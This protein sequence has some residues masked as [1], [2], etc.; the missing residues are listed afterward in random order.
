[1]VYSNSK[2]GIPE[3]AKTLIECPA[4]FRYAR[5]SLLNQ[6]RAHRNQVLAVIFRIGEWDLRMPVG[7][8][9]SLKGAIHE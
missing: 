7:G 3:P 8:D 9:A 5:T 2:F 1:M 6:R 4:G